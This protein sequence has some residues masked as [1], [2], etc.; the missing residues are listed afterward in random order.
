MT[1][2]WGDM[3][4]RAKLDLLVESVEEDHR[5]AVRA[6]LGVHF[7]THSMS[8]PTYCINVVMRECWRAEHGDTVEWD[9]VAAAAGTVIR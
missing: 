1:A 3:P 6:R 5:A 7:L 4:K 2:T 8:D 9:R